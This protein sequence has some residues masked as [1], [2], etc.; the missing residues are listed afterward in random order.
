MADGTQY[1]SRGSLSRPSPGNPGGAA[2]RALSL[3][4]GLAVATGF[5]GRGGGAGHLGELQSDRLPG[6]RPHAVRSLDPSLDVGR[7][8]YPASLAAVRTARLVAGGI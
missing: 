4:R 5:V 7:I 6:A 1:R 3:G 8:R 2:P